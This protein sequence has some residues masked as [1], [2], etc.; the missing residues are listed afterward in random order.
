MAAMRSIHLAAALSLAAGCAAKLPP[1][2]ATGADESALRA[3]FNAAADRTRV[4]ALL[5]PT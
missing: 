1:H 4:V 2:I 5:S 3:T